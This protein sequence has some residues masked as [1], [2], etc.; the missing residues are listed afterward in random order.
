MGGGVVENRIQMPILWGKPLLILRKGLP[1]ASIF[2][3]FHRR[4]QLNRDFSKLRFNS[5]AAILWSA[6]ALRASFALPTGFSAGVVSPFSRG[7]R[8]SI[9]G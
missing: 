8:T 7:Y 1:F 6:S 5:A 2:L 3:P 4:A 9:I